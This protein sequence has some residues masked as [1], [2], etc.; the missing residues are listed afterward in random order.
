MT[1]PIK[2]FTADDLDAF[3]SA[4]LSAESR[5]HLE[6]CAECRSLVLSDR[7]LLDALARLP[8]F[9]PSAGFAD[10]VMARVQIQPAAA[11]AFPWTRVAL[12]ASLLLGLGASAIWSVFNRGVLLGWLNNAAAEI[13]RGLWLGVRV[14]ATNLT[15]Q[16]WFG[17]VS[18][19]LSSS[20]RV[21]LIGG[22][23]LVGYGVAVFALRRLLVPPSRPVPDANW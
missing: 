4:S 5:Q 15:E 8:S 21:A 20:G 7:A 23:L 1:W 19:A 3:H 16:P 6:A 9:E 12:A 11:R 14:L 18:Q 10:R 2:H 17:T 13:G 22:V